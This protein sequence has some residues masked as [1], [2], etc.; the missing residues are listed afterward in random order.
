[1]SARSWASREQD[2]AE[3]YRQPTTLW[4][5][6][7]DEANLAII[8]G[9]LDRAGELA[10]AALEI[11]QQSEPDALA[12]YA[13]QSTSIAF[14]RGAM[15]DLIPLLEQAAREN[16]GVPGF[17][18]TLAL[19]LSE[20]EQPDQA[21]RLIDSAASTGFAELPYDVAWLTAVCIYARV[22][23]TLG[24]AESAAALYPMLVPW[25]DQIA[26]PAFGVWGPVGLYLGPLARLLGEPAAAEQHLLS[27]ARAA[28]RAG[29]PLWEARAAAERS[30]LAE[31][32][33]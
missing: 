23:A 20:G 8:A 26:F 24:D 9:N 15:N 3:R 10:G 11:G 12:C 2:I 25:A 1:V 17:R 19:A 29:A 18:A 22:A 5:R 31:L 7:A 32:T 21:R 14:E 13:A 4:L 33:R 30:R 6:C 16:P 28:V 27:A